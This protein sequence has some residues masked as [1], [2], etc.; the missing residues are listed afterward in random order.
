M[1]ENHLDSRIRDQFLKK[2]F[3]TIFLAKHLSPQTRQGEDG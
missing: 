2:M 1:Y 3:L